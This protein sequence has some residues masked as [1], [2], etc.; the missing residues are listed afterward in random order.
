M[1]LAASQARLLLLTARKSDL[2]YRAQCITNTEMILAMQTE[3]VARKYSNAISNTALFYVKADNET[4]KNQALSSG[5]FA[6]IVSGAFRLEKLVGQNEDGSPLY[7]PYQLD[8][9]KANAWTWTP[10]RDMY[11]V[12]KNGQPQFFT[13][14]STLSDDYSESEGYSIKKYAE[15]QP[16]SIDSTIHSL[17]VYFEKSVNPGGFQ[18]GADDLHDTTDGHVQIKGYSEYTNALD[19]LQL[20]QM[21]NNG[22]MRI[23]NAA[24]NTEVSLSGNTGFT[25]TYY[26]DD[27][28]QAEAEYK[29]ATAAIQIKEKRLQNDLH[30]VET[31]QKACEQEIDSVK[32][33]MDKNI[34]KTFKVFS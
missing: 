26:T 7:A 11:L 22:Q 10:S 23:V 19:P 34:E 18:E 12:E 32:K 1:G 30:Q 21:I 24:D 33:V 29:R 20:M 9:G 4:A 31:Q 5:V 28:A 6:G 27:D 8:A 25:E 16:V 3:E 17:L 2:E 14:S 15:G 13:Y